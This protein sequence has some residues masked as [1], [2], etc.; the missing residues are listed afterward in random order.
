MTSDKEKIREYISDQIAQVDFRAHGYV[1]DANNKKRLNRNI[2]IRLQSYFKNFLEGKKSYRWI[3]LTGLRG[4]GKTTLMYQLYYA[5]KNIDAYFLVLSVDEVVKTINSSIGE[6]LSVFEEVIGKPLSNLDKPLFL[7]LDEV[8]YD[9]KW[10]ITLKTLYDRADNVFIFCTG[11]AAVLVNTNSDIARRAIYEK[12]YPLSFTEF[13]R[14]KHQKTES[15][16]IA[17][18]LR[19]SIFLAQSAKEVFDNLN[20][21]KGKINKYY[22]GI[23]RLEFENYLYYGSLPFMISLNNEA[24]IY[25]Q[26]HKSLERVVNKDIPQMRAMTQDIIGKIPAILY[27]IA[28]MDALNFST[29]AEKFGIS[30]PKVTEIFLAL[31]QAEV[32]HRIYPMGS[33]FKQVTQKPSKYFFSSPA[34]R[35]MYYKTIGNTITEQNARGKLLEDLVGMYLYRLFD[36][37]P[38]FSL[39]YD[40]A[41]GGADFIV[42]I[43]EKKIVIEVGINKTEYRQVAQT[44]KKTN[45]VFNIIISEKA[46]ELEYN[47]EENA[48]KIPLK[49]FLLI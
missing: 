35:A 27:A 1:F 39:T 8:Q 44:A 15:K 9:E 47:N 5:K 28:D 41:K 10:G 17:S 45:S 43:G 38:R 42:G 37:K 48:V 40:S 36:K 6:I 30:R 12:I 25:D 24:I 22:L 4:A 11:S 13:I 32:L 49:Y 31:E 29:L 7:F 21:L 26:I 23:S 34:F 20:L 2:F 3:A 16:G 33:H 19:D 46:D 14:I 18:A